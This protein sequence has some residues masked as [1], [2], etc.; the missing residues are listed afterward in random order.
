MCASINVIIAPEKFYVKHDSDIL[1]NDNYYIRNN[2]E[3][4]FININQLETSTINDLLNIIFKSENN[5][6]SYTIIHI[7]ADDNKFLNIYKILDS[8][9]N[10]KPRIILNGKYQQN[11]LIKNIETKFIFDSII[12]CDEGDIIKYSHTV[13]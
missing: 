11:S 4:Y 2:T 5:V 1:I 7:Y 3:Y 6:R 9:T 8:S 10:I 13:I 12:I